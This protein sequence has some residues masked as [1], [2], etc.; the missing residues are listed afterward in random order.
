M[1]TTTNRY[2]APLYEK[3][4]GDLLVAIRDNHQDAPEARAELYSRGWED[5]YIQAYLK[6][7]SQG[8]LDYIE[9]Q[10][11]ISRVTFDN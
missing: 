10:K 6:G 9:E 5:S 1:N 11:K 7:G 2:H 8:L 4:E 3:P